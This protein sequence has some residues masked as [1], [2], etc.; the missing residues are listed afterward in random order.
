[1]GFNSAFKGLI[2]KQK[3][4]FSSGD[5]IYT[6]IGTAYSPSHLTFGIKSR[7][8]NFCYFPN[9]R[10]YGIKCPLKAVLCTGID[11]GLYSFW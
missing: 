10:S 5:G 11:F 9:F 3:Q 7:L 4:L 2:C 6:N 1:M 8:F